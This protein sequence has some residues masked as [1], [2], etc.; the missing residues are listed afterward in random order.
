MAL[1]DCCR[2]RWAQAASAAVGVLGD[3]RVSDA[4]RRIAAEEA[5]RAVAMLRLPGG[6]R[7]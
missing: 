1:C 3:T 2:E 7:R 6:E 4:E 5:T